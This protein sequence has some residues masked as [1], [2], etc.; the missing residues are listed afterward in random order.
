MDLFW[1]IVDKIIDV[2]TLITIVWAVKTVLSNAHSEMVAPDK[3]QDNRISNVE[4]RC[5][6]MEEHLTV[7]D[8][9]LTRD[10]KRMNDHEKF[11]ELS[12]KAQL[13]L[14]NHALSGNN[15]D[16]LKQVKEEFCEKTSVVFTNKEV[17]E[18]EEENK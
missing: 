8:G 9:K 15:M 16:E 7:I 2:G 17:R 4:K 14:V 3:L 18:R 13:A 10:Y 5:D 6:V 11:M 1:M 12:I